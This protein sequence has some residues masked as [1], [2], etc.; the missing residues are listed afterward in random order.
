M[1]VDL[2]LLG[3]QAK[4]IPKAYLRLAKVLVVAGHSLF[5]FTSSPKKLSRRVGN[6]RSKRKKDLAMPLPSYVM[7][8]LIVSYVFISFLLVW[9]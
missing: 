3:V 5:L 9:F 8:Q 4:V 2:T 7:L 1:D 6:R